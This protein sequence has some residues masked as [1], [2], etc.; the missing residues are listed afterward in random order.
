[1]NY[2][3]V[4]TDSELVTFC[5]K[6]KNSQQLALDTEFVRTRTYYPRLGLIQV[7]NA[8]HLALIDPLNIQNWQCFTDIL[9]SAESQK[10]FHACSEDLDVFMHEF[11]FIPQPLLDSQVVAAFLDNPI[12]SGYA[13]LV[14]KYLGVEL[15]K[16]ET[17]T[18]WLLR[19]LTDKQC[20]YAA[21][22]V[23]YLIPLMDKLIAQINAKGW[24]AAAYEDCQLS[25]TR[26]KQ[27]LAS[28]DA[29]LVIKNAWQLKTEALSYLKRLAQ[30]RLNYARQHDI[31]VNFIVHEE[32]LWKIAKYKP[33]SL[34]ELESLGMRGKEIRLYG[35][36]ILDFLKEPLTEMVEPIRQVIDYPDYKKIAT[37]IKQQAEIVAKD[38]DL[39]PELIVSR[40][41]INQ[42]VK[43]L[44]KEEAEQPELLSGWRGELLKG[45]L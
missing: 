37:H 38:A 6:I 25:I 30:W 5:E 18:D 9:K 40:R 31:A 19:P 3:L 33:T 17:R 27:V 1:M 14:N 39:S 26:K 20:H 24:L 42:Y 43:W 13:T 28:A 36:I 12:S 2:Q 23:Y 22:D 41:Q 45:R 15:D 10:Y 35:Q 32:V 21:A 4:T 34:A 16:S 44:N 7:Y 29:Y 11:N 8:Q